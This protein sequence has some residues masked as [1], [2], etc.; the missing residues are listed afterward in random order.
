M[1]KIRPL[2][3]YSAK[4]HHLKALRDAKAQIDV[5]F[6]VQPL[7]AVNGVDGR[8]LAFS[9]HPGFLCE[10]FLVASPDDVPVALR[11]ALGLVE[12]DA[13]GYAEKLSR[14]FKR[15]VIEIV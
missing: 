1:S 14:W 10:S 15:E 8:V 7:G 4:P 12:L 2:Y 5:D 11:W 13:D 6:L 9:E 3:L